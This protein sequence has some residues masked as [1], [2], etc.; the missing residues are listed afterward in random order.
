[1]STT[2]TQSNKLPWGIVIILAF[3]VLLLLGREISAN[4]RIDTKFFP[5]VNIGL[6]LNG[7]LLIKDSKGNIVK[8]IPNSEYYPNKHVRAITKVET[9]TILEIVGSH[10]YDLEF[11]GETYHI[12]LPAPHP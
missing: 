9:I 1:M 6:D 12:P 5:P 10:Y 2:K 3:L 7:K 8:P 11:H 4:K